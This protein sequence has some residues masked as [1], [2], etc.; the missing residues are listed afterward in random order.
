MSSL[1]FTPDEFLDYIMQRVVITPNG[2]WLWELNCSGDGRGGGYP[3]LR[4]RG[5]WYAVHRLSLVTLKGPIPAGHHA[6]HTC[7]TLPDAD[8][9]VQRRCIC[10]DHLR[11]VTPSE[12][13]RMKGYFRIRPAKSLG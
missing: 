11:A 12:N 4:R 13:E 9:W 8:P 6:G 7:T 1:P 2:C 10:P 5:R 3:R